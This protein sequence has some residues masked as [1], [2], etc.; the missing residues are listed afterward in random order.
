VGHGAAEQRDVG[1]V[2]AEASGERKQIGRRDNVGPGHGGL[3]PG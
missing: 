3:S 2:V 1:E